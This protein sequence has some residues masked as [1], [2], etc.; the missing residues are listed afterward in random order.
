M[1]LDY[2]FWGL[3]ALALLICVI[4]MYICFGMK[5]TVGIVA[6][7]FYFKFMDKL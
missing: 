4:A 7:M 6:A 1:N 3:K 2:L 5:T